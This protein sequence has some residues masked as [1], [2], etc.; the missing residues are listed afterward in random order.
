MTGKRK[1]RIC[2]KCSLQNTQEW[3]DNN[4]DHLLAIYK[5]VRDKAR[6]DVFTYYGGGKAQCTCCGETEIKFLCLDHINDDGKKHRAEL[7]KIGVSNG[8]GFYRYLRRSGFPAGLQTLCHNCNMAKRYG[9][10]P[11]KEVRDGSSLLQ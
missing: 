6:L 7:K 10:C 3:R 2:I 1:G 5:K 4:K 11:H 9:A 8:T